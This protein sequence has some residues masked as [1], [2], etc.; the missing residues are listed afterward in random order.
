MDE[1]FDVEVLTDEN[2]LLVTGSEEEVSGFL[3]SLKLDEA[4][5]AVSSP[6]VFALLGEAARGVSSMAQAANKSGQVGRWVKLTAESAEKIQKHGLMATKSGH[7]VHAVAGTPGHIKGWLQFEKGGTP[8][9]QRGLGMANVAAVFTVIQHELEMREIQQALEG[10]DKA[11][12]RQ[13]R[14]SLNAVAS[15]VRSMQQALEEAMTL[16]IS[17]G[18]TA[19]AWSNLQHRSAEMLSTYNLA[20]EE[21]EGLRKELAETQKVKQLLEVTQHVNRLAPF[22]LKLAAELVEMR[23]LYSLIELH[24]VHDE[25]PELVDSHRSALESAFSKDRDRLQGEVGAVMAALEQTSQRAEARR[26]ISPKVVA[27]LQDTL[28]DTAQTVAELASDRG[29]DVPAIEIAHRS[30]GQS[31]KD[32]RIGRLATGTK[33]TVGRGAKNSGT[34]IAGAIAKASSQAGEVGRKLKQVTPKK[35]D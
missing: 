12:Q 9:L 35:K 34:T 8:L 28:H 4:A 26:A 29:F 7:G 10:V 11:L 21:L 13:E 30:W 24:Q 19:I 6:A 1:R 16:A 32:T 23:G 25:N 27:T 5:K 22:W 33:E 15:K 17:G 14:R 18:D 3:A 20:L 2:Q 31:V